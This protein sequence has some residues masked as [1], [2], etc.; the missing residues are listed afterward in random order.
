MTLTQ[1]DTPL[2]MPEEHRLAGVLGDF[3]PNART[4]GDNGVVTPPLARSTRR[5]RPA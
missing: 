2:P 4:I 1:A 3:N 5:R